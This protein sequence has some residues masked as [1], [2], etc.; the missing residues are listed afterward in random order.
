MSALMDEL[1]Q[2]H[3]LDDDD[4]EADEGWLDDHHKREKDFSTRRFQTGSTSTPT[5]TRSTI[6]RPTRSNIARDAGQLKNVLTKCAIGATEFKGKFCCA[7]R[8]VKRDLGTR[9]KKD[10]KYA[11]TCAMM[12]RDRTSRHTAAGA[13]PRLRGR[14]PRPPTT[15]TTAGW[16]RCW[17]VVACRQGSHRPW[18]WSHQFGFQRKTERRLAASLRDHGAKRT[19]ERLPTPGKVGR[20]A[21]PPFGC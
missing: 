4:E 13:A 7:R 9:F 5:L 15:R 14:S 19:S 1:I 6:C 11:S 20:Q 10:P 2:S 8:M 16:P 18:R 3:L 12:C 17:R 21:H